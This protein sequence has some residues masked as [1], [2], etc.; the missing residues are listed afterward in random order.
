MIYVSGLVVFLL[1]LTAEAQEVDPAQNWMYDLLSTNDNYEV[2]Q[3]NPATWVST[4]SSMFGDFDDSVQKLMEYFN[5]AN[6]DGTTFDM[7]SPL[8][9]TIPDNSS[10]ESEIMWSFLL[11]SLFSQPPAP[12]DDSLFL[13]DT[14]TMTVLALSS[15]FNNNNM[16]DIEKMISD[17]FALQSIADS[18][19]AFETQEFY[20]AFF[21]PL[22]SS[23]GANELWFLAP[24]NP[25]GLP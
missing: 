18:V 15:M 2:R 4:N 16:F 7:V 9:M 6:A 19:G 22:T 23:Q 11:P 8:I 14:T 17:D 10:L 1:A 24:M 13:T 12:H 20:A 25:F 5:G 21:N 3:Y